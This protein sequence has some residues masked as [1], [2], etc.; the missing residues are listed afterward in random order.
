MPAVAEQPHCGR[1][2][3][4][5]RGPGALGVEALWAQGAGGAWTFG[6]SL[7]FAVKQAS[8]AGGPL[9]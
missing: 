9:G 7:L 2:V 1:G 6:A 4:Q 8:E 3:G 5:E